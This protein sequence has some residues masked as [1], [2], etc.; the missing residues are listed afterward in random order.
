MD[1]CE[2]IL[3]I[4]FDGKRGESYNIGA[5]NELDNITIVKK[6]LDIM[7]KPHSLIHFTKDRPGH[8]FRY[9]LNTKKIKRDL[10]WRPKY[11]FESGL[12]N[13]IKWYTENKEWKKKIS[14]NDLLNV[15]WKT[16]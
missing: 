15:S 9:S 13:T 1:H 16:R 8:D 5:G 2:A 12:R 4:L 3:R 14:S 7:E 11:D 6:I 10:H